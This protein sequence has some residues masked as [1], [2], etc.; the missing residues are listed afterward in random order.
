MNTIVTS[1]SVYV[2]K[3]LSYTMTKVSYT[4]MYQF[5][6]SWLP[7]MSYSQ[8]TKLWCFWLCWLCQSSPF[9]TMMLTCSPHPYLINKFCCIKIT[10]ILIL[11]NPK[12][13]SQKKKN[14]SMENWWPCLQILLFLSLFLSDDANYWVRSTITRKN[15]RTRKKTIV[16]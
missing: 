1:D 15:T 13:F 11:H 2:P 4:L 6:S 16:L 5:S 12:S 7:W 14:F 8:D 10:S 3:N 9:E